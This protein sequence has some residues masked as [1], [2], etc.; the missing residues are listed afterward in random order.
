MRPPVA[1][2]LRPTICTKFDFFCFPC[3]AVGR[4]RGDSANSKYARF[5]EEEG[6]ATPEP[7]IPTATNYDERN[8]ERQQALC[9]RNVSTADVRDGKHPAMYTRRRRRLRRCSYCPR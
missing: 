7:P 9:A 4:C 5:D 6:F 2:R 1:F 8:E 3:A